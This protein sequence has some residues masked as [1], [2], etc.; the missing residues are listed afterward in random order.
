VR[1][2]SEMKRALARNG[3]DLEAPIQ[4]D[5]TLASI[6]ESG[7]IRFNDTIVLKALT[8]GARTVSLSDFPD[9]T[10][11]EAFVNH[12]H[13]EDYVPHKNG[14]SGSVLLA[15]GISL[16]KDLGTLLRRSFPTEQFR[17]I[18]SLE[19]SHCTV[20]FHKIRP[21][22]QWLFDDLEGYQEEALI[23]FQD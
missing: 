16:A 13:V 9:E 22:Q 15:N 23:V 7:F 1:L 2:N 11:Y 21:G 18:V 20:R 4:L 3:V 17:I 19:K 12:I 8:Q 5:P 14:S 10:G 6:L